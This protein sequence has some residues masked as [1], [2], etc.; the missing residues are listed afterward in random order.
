MPE[1]RAKPALTI[2]LVSALLSIAC[3]RSE[4]RGQV[5]PYE[6]FGITEDDFGKFIDAR[7]K[8]I[9]DGLRELVGELEE[10]S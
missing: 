1:R 9:A 10:S 6:E 8:R 2:A 5:N 4:E 7:A 3:S